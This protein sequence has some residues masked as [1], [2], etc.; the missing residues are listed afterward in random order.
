M[1]P[2]NSTT[3]SSAIE[4]FII[5]TILLYKVQLLD[6]WGQAPFETKEGDL[7][8][9]GSEPEWANKKQ[10]ISHIISS[11]IPTYIVAG[12]PRNDL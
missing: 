9:K 4:D 10:I 5:S 1:K 2:A 3:Q 7:Y 6:L 12:V 8:V 11:N